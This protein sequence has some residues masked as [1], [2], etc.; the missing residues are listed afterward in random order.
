MPHWWAAAPRP[1]EAYMA[2][3]PGAG[4]K[5]SSPCDGS[6][7][8]EYLREQA[9]LGK[10]AGK[11]P[12]AGGHGRQGGPGDVGRLACPAW[13][14]FVSLSRIQ[15]LHPA[16]AELLQQSWWPGR[17]AGGLVCRG[18]AYS[19]PPSGS[20]IIPLS[21]RR[22]RSTDSGKQEGWRAREPRRAVAR[23][24]VW[25]CRGLGLQCCVCDK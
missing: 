17:R 19:P 14:V 24:G 21:P 15:P 4:G 8:N 20:D 16:T 11:S 9:S 6:R 3:G 7:E 1:T 23:N 5:S 13:P 18:R 12:P 22:S 10:E 2:P 25:D